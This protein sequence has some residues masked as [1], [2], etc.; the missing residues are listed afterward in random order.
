MPYKNKEDRNLRREYDNYQGK[1]EQIKKRAQRNAARRALM[2]EGVVHK[3][4][5]RDVDHVRALSK[6]GTNSRANLRVRSASSN[7]S[8]SRNSDH[9]VKSNRLKK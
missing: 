8:F 2:R 6:G 3:G 1:P 7:R 4:D 5:G 9:T